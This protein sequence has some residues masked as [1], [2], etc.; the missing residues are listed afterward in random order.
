MTSISTDQHGYVTCHDQNLIPEKSML[1]VESQAH[2][3]LGEQTRHAIINAALA[4]G[5]VR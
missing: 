4:A 1:D 5:N 2:T 3:L